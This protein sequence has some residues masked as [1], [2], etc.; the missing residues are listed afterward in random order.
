MDTRCSLEDLTGS[1]D[2]RDR[3]R[4]RERERES[5]NR[6]KSMRLDY[7]DD[8]DDDLHPRFNTKLYLMVRLQF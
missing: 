1:M 8:D 7:D 4:E 5:G 6:V 2:D 3:R